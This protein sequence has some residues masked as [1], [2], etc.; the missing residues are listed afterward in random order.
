[1][2]TR[3]KIELLNEEK[4]F[5]YFESSVKWMRRRGRKEKKYFIS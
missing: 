5:V 2:K 1:M 3:H 4:K